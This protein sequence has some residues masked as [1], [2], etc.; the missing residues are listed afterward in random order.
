MAMGDKDQTG[1]VKIA[2]LEALIAAAEAAGAAPVERWDPPYCGDIG[3][4]IAADG[5]WFYRGS[6]IARRRLVQLFARVLWRDERGQHFLVTPAEKVDVAVADAPFLA[7]EMEIR[8]PGAGAGQD[9]VFRTNVDDVVIADAE[10]PIRFAVEP[11][12]GGLKPYVT[13]RGRLEALVVRSLTHDLL[14]AAEEGPGGKLGVWSR[15]LF[16]P[17]PD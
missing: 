17:V 2:G 10:H 5:H 9:I 6:E 1:M 16:F 8:H 7:V 13:V 4:A 14:A 12:H 15:G 11:E 3:L